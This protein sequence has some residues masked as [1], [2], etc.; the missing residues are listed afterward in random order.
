MTSES[1]VPWIMLVTPALARPSGGWALPSSAQSQNQGPDPRGGGG[2]RPG[3]ERVHERA[4]WLLVAGD[5]SCLVSRSGKPRPESETPAPFVEGD[6]GT[7][8]LDVTAQEAGNRGAASKISSLTS[9][10]LLVTA[11]Q[12]GTHEAWP[13][14]QATSLL[15][16]SDF[17]LFLP[18][19]PQTLPCPGSS[20]GSLP[21]PLSSATSASPPVSLCSFSH[22]LALSLILQALLLGEGTLTHVQKE[23]ESFQPAV[24]APR[25]GFPGSLLACG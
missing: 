20:E 19:L 3:V 9:S 17:A 24:T 21:P 11:C 7:C 13:L 6:F 1:R 8:D 16:S 23:M 5:A 14:G 10:G 15:L 4:R 2:R 22:S 18:Q 12:A 25:C